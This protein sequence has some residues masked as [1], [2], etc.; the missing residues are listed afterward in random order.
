MKYI[1]AYPPVDFSRPFSEV[2]PEEIDIYFHYDSR[3]GGP[4]CKAA[5]SHCYFRNQ[6]AF[7][8]PAE[9]ALA[10]TH[11]LREQGYNIGMAPADSFNDEALD[12]GD[13]G[14]AYRLKTVNALAWTS[15]MPLM[16]PGWEKR[17]ARA[18]EIGFRSI[19]MNAHE[20]AGTSVPL[21]GVTKGVVIQRALAN[22][23]SWNGRSS[24]RSFS[25]AVTF[26]IRRDNCELDLMRQMVAW[27]V[28]EGLEL[29][30]FNAFSNFQNLPEHKVYELTRNDI[31]RFY[32]C[33]AELQRE[34][35]ETPTALG[36]SEDWGDAGIEQIYPFLTPEWQSRS[37]GW[38][39][40]GYR[41]FALLEV[42]GELVLTGCVDK[43]DPPVGKV[44]EYG[45]EFKI[46]WDYDR[47]ETI[48]QAVLK[49]EVYA[50]WGGVG[51]QRP[52]EA[53]FEI[54]PKTE[55]KIF[56]KSG[57]AEY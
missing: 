48:R 36:I 52:P 4:T 25:R 8:I 56:E 39:R 50:C 7:H 10:I 37:I 33:L 35:L 5:C 53:G 42:K 47:I 27:G 45:G 3:I 16:L 12:A 34:F 6:P 2:R 21:A 29:V 40:T 1:V 23:R 9:R 57:G 49:N 13:A 26:T 38:C 24:D 43:W 46:A 20:A 11:S 19:V 31:V 28:G 14:S 41:L 44:L 30:R 15:G 55:A 54:D 22:I 51:C 18:Y 17:L 32:A